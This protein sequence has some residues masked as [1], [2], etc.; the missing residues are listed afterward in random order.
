MA[1]KTEGECPIATNIY[2]RRRAKKEKISIKKMMEIYS[3]ESETPYATLDRWVY[4]RKKKSYV[5]NDVTPTSLN[6]TKLELK[7]HVDK[8][9]EKITSG[10]M[11]EDKVKEIVDSV[12][13]GIEKEIYPVRV[14][15]EIQ[16]T[17]K[18]GRQKKKKKG[19]EP[20]QM[21]KFDRLHKL[22]S[23]F[24]VG[25]K[26]WADG[27]MKPENSD[28]DVCAQAILMGAASCIV[29]YGRLG[30]DVLAFMKRF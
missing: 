24:L 11:S 3:K 20:K 8:V 28:E 5:E 23:K 26:A 29:Q 21:D 15:T 7:E 30:I 25:L 18:P 14:G 16:P 27:K 4:P 22:S 17:I 2:I 10:E 19:P 1:R 6:E 13:A 9:I 12:A